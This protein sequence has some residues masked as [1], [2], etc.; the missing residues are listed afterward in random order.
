MSRLLR[1]VTVGIMAATLVAGIP[2]VSQGGT[3]RIKAVGTYPNFAWSPSS[4]TVAKGTTV[5]W[6]NSTSSKHSVTAY[7]NGWSKNSV[8]QPG[9]KTKFKFTKAGT[10]YF[11]CHFHSSVSNG[12]CSGS[13]C[14]KVKVTK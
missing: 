8:I 3:A 2:A 12:Q 9:D 1:L 7:K 10:Y 11:Y 13:M 6:K 5:V 4:K 14:G